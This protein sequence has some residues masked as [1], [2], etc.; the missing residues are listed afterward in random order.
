[1]GG[2]FW[3]A[4]ANEGV[5]LLA[6]SLIIRLGLHGSSQL[7]LGRRMPL[8]QGDGPD[9]VSPKLSVMVSHASRRGV[10]S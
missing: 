8:G 5:R 6:I 2:V 4:S 3:R 1:M 9:D 10:L 7:G